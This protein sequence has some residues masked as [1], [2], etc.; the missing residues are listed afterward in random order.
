MVYNVLFLAKEL[1]D[2][3][4]VGEILKSKLLDEKVSFNIELASKLED[5][6]E[7]LEKNYFN[8]ILSE[9]ELLASQ[10]FYIFTMELNSKIYSLKYDY[11][12]DVSYEETILR[13]ALP[14]ITEKDNKEKI[15]Q[16]LLPKIE[17]LKYC[18]S[19]TNLLIESMVELESAEDLANM[20]I[21][22]GK[23]ICKQYDIKGI[24]RSDMLR[25][26][27]ILAV[28][29]KK[30]SLIKTI[31]FFERMRVA[32]KIV[33]LLHKFL[34]PYTQEG[35]IIHTIYK[36]VQIELS[37]DKTHTKCCNSDVPTQIHDDVVEVIRLH[38]VFIEQG[39]DLEQIWIRV[40]DALN[41]SDA[42]EDSY[43]SF[44]RA[45][46]K[47]ARYAA[48]YKRG[49]LTSLD[50]NNGSLTFSIKCRERMEEGE[51]GAVFKDKIA[52]D[53]SLVF[54]LDENYAKLSL[55]TE[56]KGRSSTRVRATWD[57]DKRTPGACGN[58]TDRRDRFNPL[59]FRLDAGPAIAAGR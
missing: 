5:K 2:I 44:V 32:E 22:Y 34:E 29:L 31:R 57:V 15:A 36:H 27:S 23:S 24:D 42:K 20:M 53:E 45:S 7:L 46:M 10:N 37:E 55:D 17:E 41:K 25:V 52:F 12:T 4:P 13:G 3:R 11:Q 58:P 26:L 38:K 33:D 18:D 14:L 51:I 54:E 28:S 47:L 1:D 30:R 49:G 43:D 21:G 56:I 19:Y 16:I 59:R 39:S 48:C 40:I 35:Y 50:N 8:L 6:L 9:F